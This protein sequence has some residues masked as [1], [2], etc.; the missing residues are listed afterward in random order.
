MRLYRLSEN[1]PGVYCDEAALGAN[2]ASIGASG[3]DL[4]GALLPLYCRERSFPGEIVYQPVF[5]YAEIPFV[6]LLNLSP[7]SVRLPSVLFGL[8][9]VVTTFVLVRR[10]QGRWVAL[11]ASAVLAICPWHL[12]F[13]RIAFEAISLPPLL[14]LGCWL[15]WRGLEKRGALIGGAALLGV[16]TYAYPPAK[17]MVPLLLLAF[18]FTHRKALANRRRD[19]LCAAG[20]LVLIALPNLYLVLFGKQQARVQQLLIFSADLSGERAILFLLAREASVW[21]RA[22]L[23]TPLLR[24]PFVFVYNY[25]SYLSPDYLFAHGD[26]NLRHNPGYIGMYYRTLAP[27]MVTGG[28]V[29]WINRRQPAATFFLLWLLAFPI[30][31]SLTV[32]S[33]HAVRAMTAFPVFEVLA[34][35]GAVAI[36][37]QALRLKVPSA[38]AYWPPFLAAFTVVAG[39]ILLPVEMAAYLRDYHGHYRI[40]SGAWWQTGMREAVALLEREKERYDRVIISPRV[41]HAY[42]YLVFFGAV[43]AGPDDPEEIDSRL[44]QYRYHLAKPLERPVANPR[45]LWWVTSDEIR[46]FPPPTSVTTIPYPDGT[47]HF[48]ILGFGP[49]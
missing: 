28:V 13:S 8:A 3:R 30:P 19:L 7:L 27:F 38:R 35:V 24:I 6:R 16:A 32:D 40:S 20:L 18:A 31:A 42:I 48:S 10:L 33:P 4:S 9:S 2:A 47:P 39:L 49:G 45:E 25:L 41:E 15:L 21:A 46:R 11:I 43:H 36:V 14:M 34:S 37:S 29:L 5:L 26:P 44:G 22:I 17:L 12:Q 1:P 23:S